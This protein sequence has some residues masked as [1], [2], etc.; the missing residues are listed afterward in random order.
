MNG[1]WQ[2]PAARGYFLLSAPPDEL[3]EAAFDPESVP[4]G[5]EPESV[6]GADDEPVADAGDAG[7]FSSRLPFFA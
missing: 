1:G 3:A 6:P 4:A 2:P 5:L 7:G